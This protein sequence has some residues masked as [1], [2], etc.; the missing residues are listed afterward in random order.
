MAFVGRLAIK[1]GLNSGAEQAVNVVHF[2][3]P[4]GAGGLAQLSDF[5]AKLN[6]LLVPWWAGVKTI[7]ST[8]TQIASYTVSDIDPAT[9]LVNQSLAVTPANITATGERAE[10][11]L[12]LQCAVVVSFRTLSASVRGRVYMPAHTEAH[13]DAGG[14]FPALGRDAYADAWEDL[15]NDM[16]LDNPNGY[17]PVVM[18]RQ[19]GS[20]SFVTIQSLDVGSVVDTQRR[21]RGDLVETRTTRILA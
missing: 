14:T 9:G 3:D 5:G 16:A 8:T 1:Y 2:L 13:N 6:G 10:H 17:L 15:F 12:P 11:Q 20:P 4:D 7:L 18:S 19:G 21:R